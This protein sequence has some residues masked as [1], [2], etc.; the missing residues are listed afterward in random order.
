M[1]HKAL[2]QRLRNDMLFRKQGILGWNDGDK[3]EHFDRDLTKELSSTPRMCFVP[4]EGWVWFS[5][6]GLCPEHV[7]AATIILSVVDEDG[8]TWW[9]EPQQPGKWLTPV[10]L[11]FESELKSA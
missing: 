3:A 7:H 8:E 10:H 2:G 9:M 1:P 11:L 6:Q 5:A 4:A